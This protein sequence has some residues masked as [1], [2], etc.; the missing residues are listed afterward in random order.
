MVGDF[1][2]LWQVQPRLGEGIHSLSSRSLCSYSGCRNAVAEDQ[3]ASIVLRR[4]PITGTVSN[5]TFVRVVL[6][7]AREFEGLLG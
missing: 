6:R 4:R 1:A 7:N 2:L 3:L 5:A